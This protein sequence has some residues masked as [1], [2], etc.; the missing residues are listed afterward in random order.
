[1]PKMGPKYHFSV[2]TGQKHCQRVITGQ[3]HCESDKKHISSHENK[4]ALSPFGGFHPLLP[5][6]FFLFF[7]L[8]LIL[9]HNR[10]RRWAWIFLSSMQKRKWKPPNGLK[11][12]LF[13][14]DDMNGFLRS[15]MIHWYHLHA[16][17]STG[18]YVEL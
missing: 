18:Y 15:I 16:I 3:K 7:I 9:G 2:I 1:M 4:K 5:L 13:S 17:I 11:A 12:F 10:R 8:F 6:F 14:W